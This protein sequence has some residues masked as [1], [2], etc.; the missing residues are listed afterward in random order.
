MPHRHECGAAV[1]VDGP[2]PNTLKTRTVVVAV[3]SRWTM[4]DV[5]GVKEGIG[6]C[7]HYGP[8]VCAALDVTTATSR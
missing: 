8:E 1:D 2:T 3:G 4:L 5:P 7:V 6:T